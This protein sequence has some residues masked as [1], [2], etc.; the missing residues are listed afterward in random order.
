MGY[1]EWESCPRCK[2]RLTDVRWGKGQKTSIG[3]EV[4]HCPNCLTP[5]KTGQS[6]W[7]SKDNTQRF[8]YYLL[9]AFWVFCGMIYMPVFVMLAGTGLLWI[10]GNIGLLDDNRYTLS[11]IIIFVAIAWVI[12][13]LAI[14]IK[15]RR[16]IRESLQRQPEG[17]GG[18]T[19][20]GGRT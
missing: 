2:T 11:L 4:M 20:T 15:V 12:S 14:V 3:P 7:A 13:L 8:E 16:E 19:P 17:M 18:H 5:L 6:E 9:A 1:Y 10:T